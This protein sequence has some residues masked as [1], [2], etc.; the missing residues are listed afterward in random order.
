[1]PALLNRHWTPA[2]FLRPSK[3]GEIGAVGKPDA[4][5]DAPTAP[6]GSSFGPPP[7]SHGRPS[8]SSS[9]RRQSLPPPVNNHS[10]TLLIAAHADRRVAKGTSCA[11]TCRLNR[12]HF[13]SQPLARQVRS[14]RRDARPECRFRRSG[15][16]EDG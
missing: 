15:T 14:A 11:P 9:D 10:E 7:S 8:P 4:R 1:R 2:A 5:P 3:T 16:K 12:G 13:S 6:F